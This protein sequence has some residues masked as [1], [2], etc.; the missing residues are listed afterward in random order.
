MKAHS[1]PRRGRR[2]K[3][4]APLRL[5]GRHAH[6]QRTRYLLALSV[7]TGLA[8]E[9][10]HA[11]A[12][13][14]LASAA[15]RYLVQC[16]DTTLN[17]YA[18]GIHYEMAEGLDLRI[19]P[20]IAI[21]PPPGTLSYAVEASTSGTQDVSVSLAR[22]AR[23]QIDGVD[24]AGI[25]ATG[26]GNVSVVSGG[27][28]ATRDATPPTFDSVGPYG[29]VADSDGDGGSLRIRLLTGASVLTDGEA[30]A[31]IYAINDSAGAATVDVAGSIETL[32]LNSDGVLLFNRN[33]ANNTLASVTLSPS[34]RVR[35]RANQSNGAW[36]LN[37]GTGATFLASS[38]VVRTSGDSSNGFDLR[39]S[40][41]NA[42][43]MRLE[44]G[45]GARVVTEG[46]S[47][48]GVALS[49]DGTGDI[50]LQ[51]ERNSAVLTSG[52]LSHG[53]TAQG[54][55]AVSL[56]QR[57]GSAVT[58][59]GAQAFGAV[60][61]GG[62]SANAAVGG[63]VNAQGRRATGVAVLA[64]A[65]SARL[66][67]APGA[68]IEGGRQA[69]V[70]G[71]D[72]PLGR[73]SAGVILGGAIASTLENAGAIGAR[74][75]RAIFDEGRLDGEAGNLSILNTGRLTGFV[76]LA[77]GGVNR[78]TNAP[79]GVWE[80]RH[81]A[82]TDGDGV[83][84]TRR[85]AISDFGAPGSLFFNN[86]GATV[87]L[88]PATAAAV[89]D[90]TGYYAPSGEPAASRLDT[91]LSPSAGPG[92]AQGQFVNLGAFVHAGVLD[93]RGPNTGNSLV[94]TSRVAA[95]GPAG[96]G[97]FVSEGGTLLVNAAFDARGLADV[98]AVDGTRRG[99][100]ATTIVVDRR[101]GDGAATTGNGILVVDVRNP[102][103]SD[104][105][106]FA[107]RGDYSREGRPLIIRGARAYGL[108]FNGVGQADHDGRWY[109]RD[110]ALA[111]TVPVYSSYPLALQ[112]LIDLPT[113]RQRAGQHDA[114]W[115][116][117]T[118][119]AGEPEAGSRPTADGSV[120]VRTKAGHARQ[121]LD[122]STGKA[123]ADAD[124]YVLQAGR[125]WTLSSTPRNIVLGGLNLQYGQVSSQVRSPE[126]SGRVRASG[127]GAGA[128]LTW[129]AARG[130]YTDLQAQLVSTAGD[131]H[132]TTTGAPLIRNN[133]GLGHAASIEAGMPLAL[134]PNWRIT[135]QAQL[136]YSNIRFDPFTDPY[137]A[138]VASTQGKDM[139]L[140]LGLD[141]TYRPGGSDALSPQG[142]LAYHGGVNL[143]QTLR[144][145]KAVGIT[146]EQFSSAVERTLAGLDLGVHYTGDNRVS[147]Y[148][149][150]SAQAGL[151]R[152]GA[153]YALSGRLGL[154][155]LW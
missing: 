77:P 15:P 64:Q 154:R 36:I 50:Q 90:T 141:L 145:S 71:A 4:F 95:N 69:D 18:G 151:D 150:V 60:L 96:A 114:P 26:A 22:G 61:V 23:I 148:A 131:I 46:A 143:Y 47:A 128:T 87:R 57:A 21:T 40:A 93:L 54:S 116:H 105:E 94:M 102:A 25:L 134:T 14:G 132:S 155:L 97:V 101:E 29:I 70:G 53:L 107:L 147:A 6:G 82:D 33:D 122:L 62:P 9:R 42:S 27:A 79:G 1:P 11:A 38:G 138:K 106:A 75:D 65:G 28:I 35:T 129:Y 89:A 88:A 109:L 30:G 127:Y 73:P 100:A 39:A 74:S 99:Q 78:F 20:G 133:R 149:E 34:A 19:G 48:V 140:R 111:P 49:H 86:P 2:H 7:L 63:T 112:A 139:R 45:D 146:N 103:A 92:V 41:G 16:N 68:S 120:W 119:S 123:A 81:F 83:R 72:A 55:G 135:P 43:V 125:D 52:M 117:A 115:R 59:S 124:L 58:T 51:L 144:G 152:P 113:L 37:H 91:P 108:H 31:A 142:G 5:V 67:V 24:A 13:C 126:G 17:P 32:G 130:F 3:V 44:L 56:S 76:E 121:Q 80:V 12:E 98:L 10:A 8:S 153:N 84:D 104:A 66:A 136:L 137:G 110:T 118:R 85:V